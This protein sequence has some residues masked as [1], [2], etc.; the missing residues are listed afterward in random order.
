[1]VEDAASVF[2]DDCVA[3]QFSGTNSTFAALLVLWVAFVRPKEW[4]DA[5]NDKTPHKKNLKVSSPRS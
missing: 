1:M 2:A 3:R 4:L 5:C